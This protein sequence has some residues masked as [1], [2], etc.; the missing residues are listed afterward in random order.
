M[1][2]DVTFELVYDAQADLAEGPVWNELTGEL[3]W[4]DL[5]AGWVHRL[6][7]ERRTNRSFEV[8]QPLGAAALRESGGLVLAMR[9]GFATMDDTGA[10]DLIA[11]TEADQPDQRM[12]DGKC[13]RSGRF[14][15]GTTSLVFKP[16]SSTLYRLDTDHSVTAV[17]SGMTLS[18][19]LGW[20]P[21]DSTMYVIDSFERRLDAY[22]FDAASGSVTGQRILVTF[23]EGPALPDGMAVDD[24][25]YL[26]VAMYAGGAL[27]RYAPNGA[28]DRV[29]PV[30]ASQPTSCAF[31]GA[32]Y[33][34][35]YVTTA[36]QTKSLAELE[37][38]PALGGIFRCRPGVTGPPSPRFGG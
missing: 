35:L 17:V 30:P 32:D 38:E 26:W 27:H 15:A 37:A 28:L 9:D 8:G 34:D 12:N 23:P 18:N 22:D 7:P 3:F 20:S 5:M 2:E 33:G 24:E 4:V 19:G 14:W 29:L 25:G 13:D 10:I 36:R 21:D 11:P 6:D 1:N 31:G 16:G